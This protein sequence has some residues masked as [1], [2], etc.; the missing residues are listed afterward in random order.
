MYP[1][2]I[3]KVI[4]SSKLHLR[5]QRN[6]STK[7]TLN[8]CKSDASQDLEINLRYIEIEIQLIIYDLYLFWSIFWPYYCTLVDLLARANFDNVVSFFY[9]LALPVPIH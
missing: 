9:I 5:I 3:S 6:L 8:G 1:R 7:I 2:T 4:I